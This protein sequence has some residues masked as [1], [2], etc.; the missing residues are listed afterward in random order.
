M[1]ASVLAEKAALRR[2]LLDRRA[3]RTVEER[4]A[5]GEALAL[6]A[7]AI[8]ALTQGPRVACYLSFE[9]EPDTAA[10]IAGLR[11]RGLDVI[12]PLSRPVERALDWALVDDGGTVA[13]TYGIPEPVGERLGPGAL[14]TCQVAFVP[15]LAVDHRGRRLGRGAGYYDR[16][17]AN[18]SG[19]VCAVV[20]ADE[21]L[22]T[23]P[24]EP[25]DVPVDLALTPT[26]VFRPER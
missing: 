9:N 18:F 23:L 22:E 15:A 4:R 5:A 10:L 2:D 17:L 20:F 13:G 8:A 26:G 1:S 24:A 11:E 25:H 7:L 21:L 6:H 19:L 12:V 14:G 3:R 16:A